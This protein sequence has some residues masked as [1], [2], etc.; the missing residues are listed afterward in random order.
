MSRAQSHPRVCKGNRCRKSRERIGGGS[1]DTHF[2]KS[3]TLLP[4]NAL[5]SVE[6]DCCGEC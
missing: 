3:L 4:N 2:S 1:L 5:V 6:E